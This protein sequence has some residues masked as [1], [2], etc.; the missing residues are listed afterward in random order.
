MNLWP[1]ATNWDYVLIIPVC[2]E[3]ADFLTQLM[4]HQKQHKALVV[5][6]VNRPANHAKSHQWDKENE[7]LLQY[8][9]E[10][11]RQK[12]ALSNGHQLLTVDTN[13]DNHF[14][15]LLLNFNAQAFDPN[16]GV[17]LA[18]RIAADTALKLIAQNNISN[19]WIFSTDADV[20]LPEGYF[21]VISDVPASTS[22][23]S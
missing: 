10:Q 14:D 9:G 17:G 5:V 3:S 2:G 21:E 11:Y 16:K 8:L 20:I 7:T 12:I 1:E 4:Q 13:P 19:R 15:V 23:L 18:R 6:I 22:A